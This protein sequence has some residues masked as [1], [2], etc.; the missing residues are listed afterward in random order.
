MAHNT[1]EFTAPIQEAVG[2]ANAITPS[3]IALARASGLSAKKFAE[4]I[5][6]ARANSLYRNEVSYVLQALFVQSA[7]DEAEKAEKGDS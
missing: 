7:V 3:V 1:R 5:N 6:D 4:A 2:V